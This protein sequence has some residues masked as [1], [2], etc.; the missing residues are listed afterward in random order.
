[1]M[2]EEEVEWINDGK[3]II[4]RGW[5]IHFSDMCAFG[6]RTE[7]PPFLNRVELINR[8]VDADDVGCYDFDYRLYSDETKRRMSR[9]FFREDPRAEAMLQEAWSTY[10]VD[11]ALRDDG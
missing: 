4:L 5:Y 2:P 1:M 6:P 9:E 3:S 7:E 10:L 8:Y 11:K